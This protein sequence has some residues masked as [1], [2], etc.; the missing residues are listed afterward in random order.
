MK[1]KIRDMETVL[2]LLLELYHHQQTDTGT[3][4]IDVDLVYNNTGEA[5]RI[6]R[7]DVL[8]PLRAKNDM[9]NSKKDMENVDI[10]QFKNS[11]KE[12]TIKEYLTQYGID[13]TQREDALYI[14]EYMNSGLCIERL[15]GGDYY[16]LLECSEYVSKD[17]DQ[18]ERLLFQYGNGDFYN[19]ETM[20]KLRKEVSADLHVLTEQL[21]HVYNKLQLLDTI[22]GEDLNVKHST[23][24]LLTM[25]SNELEN[26]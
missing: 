8:R 7:D 21:Q 4:D 5:I 26:K 6:L 17:L 12:M 9:E 16:L 25:V 13:E 14:L 22:N 2:S 24:M 19:R 1:D 20:K 23:T 3:I 15:K 11:K 10:V 18:L